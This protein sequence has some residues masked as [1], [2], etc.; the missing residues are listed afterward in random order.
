MNCDFEVWSAAGRA[1]LKAARPKVM[2]ESVNETIL[3]M[4]F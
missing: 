3:M 1:E 4:I 2:V